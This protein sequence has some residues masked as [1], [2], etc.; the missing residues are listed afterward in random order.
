M[1]VNMIRRTTTQKNQKQYLVTVPSNMWES[2]LYWD[3]F[4]PWLKDQNIDP[5]QWG[6]YSHKELWF[7]NEE[8]ALLFYLRWG[9]EDD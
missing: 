8:A 9:G 3:K 7:S 5:P 4:Y 1:G 6:V 2:Q